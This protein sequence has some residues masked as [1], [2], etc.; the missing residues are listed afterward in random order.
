MGNTGVLSRDRFRIEKYAALDERPRTISPSLSSIF[1]VLPLEREGLHLVPSGQAGVPDSFSLQASIAT[2]A[3]SGPRPVAAGRQYNQ[4][5]GTR[6]EHLG[7]LPAFLWVSSTC[8]G[9]DV[10]VFSPYLDPPRP[11]PGSPD[12]GGGEGEAENAGFSK[13][14]EEALRKQSLPGRGGPGGVVE[15]VKAL[16]VPQDSG[17]HHTKTRMRQF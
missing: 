9:L 7:V 6:H 8:C 10:R 14:A 17:P 13:E 2:V 3:C 1:P 5:S 4:L 11:G 12:Q 15:W 16:G